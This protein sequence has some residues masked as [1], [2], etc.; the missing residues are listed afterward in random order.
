MLL[1][2]YPATLE[3]LKE[4]LKAPLEAPLINCIFGTLDKKSKHYPQNYLDN[5]YKAGSKDEIK[6]RIKLKY[7]DC[8]PYGLLK[9]NCE[10]LA[11]Y[12]RYG[13]SIAV[14]VC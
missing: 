3:T 7:K 5:D 8:G 12:V 6:E 1:F 2:V 10:H 9:N 11:T 14:Q 13:V 4:K